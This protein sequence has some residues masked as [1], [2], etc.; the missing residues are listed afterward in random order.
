MHVNKLVFSCYSVFGSLTH[1]APGN[2]PTV[3]RGKKEGFP[4]LRQQLERLEKFK[5]EALAVSAPNWT[6]LDAAIFVYEKEAFGG[7]EAFLIL[8]I[9]LGGS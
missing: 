1:R 7:T 6:G 9:D 4:V 2:E 5:R 8:N 3:T